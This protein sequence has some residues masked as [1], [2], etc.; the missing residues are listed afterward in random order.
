MGH[1]AP[2]DNVVELPLNVRGKARERHTVSGIKNNLYGLNWLAKEGYVPI[3]ERDGFKVCDSTNTKIWVTR[4]AVLQ[5]YY[6]PDEELWRIPLLNR[7]GHAHRTATFRQ[8]PI[9]ILQEVPPPATQHINNIYELR[10]QP[11][12]IRYYHAAAWFPTQRTWLKAIA[13]GHYRSWV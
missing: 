10:A 11:Q 12:L 13:N 1:T 8:S 3:F 4:G 6:C 9:E 7:G 5:G 2:G